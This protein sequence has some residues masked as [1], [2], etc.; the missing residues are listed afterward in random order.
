MDAEFNL[1]Y[2]T[3]VRQAARFTSIF[4]ALEMRVGQ[5]AKLSLANWQHRQIGNLPYFSNHFNVSATVS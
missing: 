4:F 3:Q 1:D 5:F 2:L